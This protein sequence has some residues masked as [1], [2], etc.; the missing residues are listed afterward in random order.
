VSVVA[1]THALVWFVFSPHLLSEAADAAL[2]EAEDGD[3][4]TVS[5]ATLIDAWYVTQT[6]KAISE[7]QLAELRTLVTNRDSNVVLE[8]IDDEVAKKF[9]QIPR[10][11]LPDPWDRLIVAT[12]V[13]LDAPLVTR[14]RRIEKSGLVR[15]IW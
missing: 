13:V 6:T 7:D 5:V 1:D 4:I 9:E 10:A 15:T 2:Q 14:D 8:S 3:G 12:A 11:V